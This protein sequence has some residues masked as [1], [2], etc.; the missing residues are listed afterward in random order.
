M[1]LVSKSKIFTNSHI[2]DL[3]VTQL[4]ILIL[5][6][7]RSLNKK[8]EPFYRQKPSK[9]SQRPLQR[10]RELLK[11]EF[12]NKLLLICCLRIT[13]ILL[14]MSSPKVVVFKAL[15]TSNFGQKRV[16]YKFMV[17]FEQKPMC[18]FRQYYELV[19]TLAKIRN[20]SHRVRYELKIFDRNKLYI[21]RYS[22]LPKFVTNSLRTVLLSGRNNYVFIQFLRI[23]AYL[24]IFTEYSLN[25]CLFCG[26]QE[27]TTK[28]QL[29]GSL[30]L[31]ATHTQLN[32][33]Y[34][35]CKLFHFNSASTLQASQF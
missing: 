19:R 26:A 23:L 8:H 34:N 21:S 5:S 25:T 28:F 11:F 16:C 29:L 22:F 20:D 31:R 14:M 18:G 13:R 1:L 30:S 24:K 6:R 9:N 15:N 7:Q 4:E 27:R 12:V 3:S 35:L 10:A 17:L 33:N 2:I 32:I